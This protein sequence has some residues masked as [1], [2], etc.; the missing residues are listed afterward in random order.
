MAGRHRLAA[1]LLGASLA[2][3]GGRAPRR[4]PASEVRRASGQDGCTP[5]AS[6]SVAGSGLSCNCS[7]CTNALA[8]LCCK[9]SGIP[10]TLLAFEEDGLWGPRLD[11]FNE[12]TGA[13]VTLTYTPQG[14]DGMQAALEADVGVLYT[15]SNGATFS[16][17]GAGIYDSYIVQA[18]WIP[19]IVDGLENLSPRIAQTPS[20]DWLDVNSMS[21]QIVSFDNTVRAL[22]LDVDYIA[23]GWRA[24]VFERWGKSPP[25]TLEELVE[26]S[27][28]F[29]GKDHNN[30]SVADWG[31]CLTPQPNYF[32]A[33]VAPVMQR[34]RR[35]CGT[36]EAGETPICDQ[37]LTGQ[38]LF[39]D[40]ETFE[41]LLDNPGFRYAL[42][43]HAR[44][45]RASNCQDQLESLGKCDR[46]SAMQ[47]GR[48]AG[49]ISMP[50]T[51]TKMLMPPD[52]Q[53]YAPQPR[54][55]E[56]GVTVEWAV[57]GAENG[58]YWGRRVRFPGSSKA[59]DS[60]DGTLKDCTPDFCPK[61]VPHS[62]MPGV[63]V[64]YAPF[65]AEGGEAYA[66][67]GK[68]ASTK[69]DLMFSFFEWLAN[70]PPSSVPLSGLY[71]RSQLTPEAQDEMVQNGMPE[72]VAIDLVQ[73]LQ[74]L[75]RDDETE[76]ANNVQD[77]LVLGFAEY[78]NAF[79]TRIYDEFLL[80]AEVFNGSLSDAEFEDRYAAVILAL[81]GD[82][83]LINHKYGQVAQLQR[84]RTSLGFA[85]LSDQELCGRF[86]GANGANAEA[87]L[88]TG[89]V[90]QS[91]VQYVAQQ[92]FEIVVVT[93]AC[94]IAVILIIMV[95]VWL[96]RTIQ[97][98]RRLQKEAT[99]LVHMQVVEAAGK[100][101]EIQAP[102]V[103]MRASDFLNCGQ[104]IAHESA[105]DSSKLISVDSIDGQMKNFL[106]KHYTVF[107][108]HQW[109]SWEV[110][111]PSQVQFAAMH[112][113]LDAISARSNTCA[114][115]G[116]AHLELLAA[117][118][119]F[120]S[121]EDPWAWRPLSCTSRRSLAMLDRSQTTRPR[122]S[123]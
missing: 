41:P 112:R 77:L 64:N 12:C 25:E 74:F 13:K 36:T 122:R 70:L 123:C 37:E 113:A 18:P 97:T 71:R 49:V 79:G 1:L 44:F 106:R 119:R 83:E 19:A 59:Y 76:G 87:L 7:F 42:D 47:S 17:E 31:F 103:V 80:Q 20:L 73:L 14:E 39:F 88:A 66:L 121:D 65:F 58:S 23:F 92:V 9:F 104:L 54:Y 111:D 53:N 26:L 55:A 68:T 2:A 118:W 89:V 120:G 72:Q 38:N 24:D 63:L 114:R 84:W 100:V 91:L 110:P 102:F 117:P 50:G 94:L 8:D 3:A 30:D 48:C 33:F 45:L 56:D 40:V 43:L 60:E 105:R 11:E 109:L 67:R 116:R 15:A 57:G 81:K 51:M 52:D 6:A 21:R 90:C 28:F 46:K 96:L 85:E 69:K 10:A 95:C 101:S 61:A 78:M 75:F 108:S 32:Y 16:S 115:H 99:R 27:E 93:V 34:M 29:N 98:S 86:A 4:P 35:L 5:E 22:P 82:Y 62:T 107:F